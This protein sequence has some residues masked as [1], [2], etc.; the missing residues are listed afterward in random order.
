MW[1]TSGDC[2]LRLA[3]RFDKERN[4]LCYDIQIIGTQDPSANNTHTAAY[5][6]FAML[7]V[8]LRFVMLSWA[9]LGWVLESNRVFYRD[10]KKTM[11][12]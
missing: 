9:W 4:V 8:V 10:Y 2:C 3:L 5:A 1:I 7:C 12:T 11:Y 6:H